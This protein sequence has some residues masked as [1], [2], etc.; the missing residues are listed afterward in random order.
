MTLGVCQFA[1][2]QN[3]YYFN[4]LNQDNGLAYGLI[5]GPFIDSRGFMWMSSGGELVRF[6]G[7]QTKRY[8]HDE[9]DSTSFG[10]IIMVNILEDDRGDLWIQSESALNQYH[11]H[12]DNFTVYPLPSEYP[13]FF[14]SNKIRT[15]WRNGR[16]T[17]YSLSRK[18]VAIRFNT[19]TK[20][21][22]ILSTEELNNIKKHFETSRISFE[23]DERKI[24]L[25]N[26][27]KNYEI[28]STI[29]SLNENEN[30]PDFIPYN[31]YNENDSTYW[32][33]GHGGLLCFNPF[34]KVFNHFNNYKGTKIT[35]LSNIIKIG[36]QLL[37]GSD[38][39]GL[40]F[41]DLNTRQ[42]VK[43]IKHE[44][45]NE[46]SIT[47][48]QTS[49]LILN[50]NGTLVLSTSSKGIDFTN[51]YKSK[52]NWLLDGPQS[53]EM[54]IDNF[55]RSITQD[56]KGN[57][58]CATHSGAI[59][60]FDQDKKITLSNTFLPKKE[61]N[62]I[63]PNNIMV[64][65]I[66]QAWLSS[67]E[68][69]YIFNSN[70]GKITTLHHPM[71]SK[72]PNYDRIHY[73]FQLRDGRIVATGS[74][75]SL[76]QIKQFGNEYLF[77]EDLCSSNLPDVYFLHESD[78]GTLYAA[79]RQ[80]INILL[81]QK[82]KYN[83]LKSVQLE[84]D[85]KHL[86]ESADKKTLWIASS[87]GLIQLNLQDYSWQK[88]TEKDGLPINY[89]YA[90]LDDEMGNLWISTNKGICR[91]TPN[92]FDWGN[93]G[94]AANRNA[95]RN[96]NKA[97]GLQG[98]EYNTFAFLKRS[99]GEMW[100]G[101]LNGINTF[102]PKNVKD[103]E[104]IPKVQI[105]DLQVN[106]KPFK[107]DQYIGERDTLILEYEYNT[108][109]FHFVAIEYADAKNCKL[110]YQLE[111]YDAEWIPIQ[112]PAFVRYPN[113]PSGS[114]TLKIK[115]SNSDGI[116]T[117]EVKELVI[118][119]RT[120]W[121]RTV[122]FRGGMLFLFLAILFGIYKYRIR[123]IKKVEFM[124]NRIA[125]DLHDDVGSTLGS[126]SVYSEVAGMKARM[127]QPIDDIVEKM[128]NAS[129]DMIERMSDIV[130]SVKAD[131]DD[132]EKVFHRMQAFAAM[133]LP[134][135][136]IRYTFELDEKL[137]T[138][139]LDM[140]KRRNLFLIYKEAIYNSVK[141]ASCQ[142]IDII[143]SAN[144]KYISMTITD[145]G[146]GFDPSHIPAIGGNGLKNMRSRCDDM[147][148]KFTLHTNKEKGTTI[149]AE[150]P[151]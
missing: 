22:E 131:Y 38:V 46:N 82:E 43:N 78:N 101:G 37:I 144:G 11:R 94:N 98:N 71:A 128:G 24:L 48:D 52:F 47:S 74:T 29:F 19:E 89:C 31:L 100:F 79:Q 75:K 105:T 18:D 45:S 65:N 139:R 141:Y 96:Y 130:W 109:S 80:V 129:R 68:G 103:Y 36:D 66:G 84:G 63:R 110:L 21:M 148:G 134:P 53:R 34:T 120:P 50:K 33:S 60:A 40:L 86:I 57:V 70:N 5:S 8:I 113:L 117:P 30:I 77:S 32:I 135:R 64:D 92:L 14:S 27:N 69:I 133:T 121:F 147:K 81:P 108:V 35:L 112:N 136:N 67:W 87:A 62:L 122:W 3:N 126:L 72:A 93:R 25:E 23:T 73:I 123:Q 137:K 54:G 138:C 83:V 118:I 51:I 107:S 150:I 42:F 102:Y 55:I 10:G 97:D 115:A 132:L 91:F 145:D 95:F 143:I 2:A 125:R 15:S 1:A 39:L 58:W 76:L 146:E 16:I 56:S 119:I 26:H 12:S 149:I 140:T 20:Q 4:H 59:I 106:D 49:P 111:G 116:W 44:S 124:R 9:N 104:V 85:I 114:Y 17:F 151:I 90:V 7:L 41:F 142:Q 6:D 61:G 28:D 127:N 99:D 13:D 88:I